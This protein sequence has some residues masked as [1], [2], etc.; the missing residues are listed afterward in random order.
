MMAAMPRPATA[1]IAVASQAA[2]GSTTKR[3]TSFSSPTPVTSRIS[4]VAPSIL[5]STRRNGRVKICSMAA[6]ASAIMRASGPFE[7]KAGR[8]A[9]AAAGARPARVIVAIGTNK[10]RR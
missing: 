1:W 9:A 8:Y 10:A 3:I 7:L 2:W 4:S 6:R 5:A